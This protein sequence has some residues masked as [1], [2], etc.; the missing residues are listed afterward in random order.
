MATLVINLYM[1]AFLNRLLNAIF[2]CP[3]PSW[4]DSEFTGPAQQQRTWHTAELSR[5]LDERE[6]SEAK[7]TSLLPS[8]R[9]L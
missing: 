1:D 9:L 2:P 4:L 5:V 7:P 6:A 8:F 3:G